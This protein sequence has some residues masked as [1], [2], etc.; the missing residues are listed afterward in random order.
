MGGDFH[1]MNNI[2]NITTMI[3][4]FF[5]SLRTVIVQ[6][7]LMQSVHFSLCGHIALPKGLETLFKG[8]MIFTL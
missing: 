1:F 4:I 6:N 3:F 8:V 2:I 7:I 5:L